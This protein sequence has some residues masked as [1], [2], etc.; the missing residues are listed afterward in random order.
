M[1]GKFLKSYLP[2][3]KYKDQNSRLVHNWDIFERIGFFEFAAIFQWKDGSIS[4]YRYFSWYWVGNWELNWT[5]KYWFLKINLAIIDLWFKSKFLEDIT[6]LF[7]LWK[8]KI[9]ARRT[10]HLC[11]AMATRGLNCSIKTRSVSVDAA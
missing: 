2:L 4:H 10:N 6:S 9:M 3:T 5:I 1:V 7:Y 8:T 11:A